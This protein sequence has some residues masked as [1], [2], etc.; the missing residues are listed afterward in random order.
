MSS[1]SPRGDTLRAEAP[2]KINRE[3]RVGGRRS[4][5]YHE[6]RSRFVSIELSDVLEVE[7]APTLELSV[8]GLDIPGSGENLVLRAARLLARELGMEPRARIHL[9]KRI[10]IGAGLGG[11]S[12]DAARALVLLRRLWAPEFSDDALGRLA[13]E[14]GSD[15]PYFLVGGEADVTGRGENVV[16][17]PDEPPVDLLLLFPP[18]PISTKD[19]F[20]EHARRTGGDA[21]L[22]ANL[23]IETSG[24]FFGP[25]DL[26][27]AV[28]G[29]EV[30]M[31]VYLDFAAEIASER[32]MT[33]SGSTVVLRGVAEPIE[34]LL[35]QRHPEASF[36]RTRTL[37]RREYGARTSPP[38]GSTWTSPR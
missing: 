29:I 19:A 28:L 24:K 36:A 16:P 7:P 13:L 11:G 25:N 21:S 35:K 5:G 33:G 26:A 3:L 12:S 1:A 9:K 17:R 31:R 18:F 10:P 2:A 22:P 38:G 15:V 27:S 34:S 32:E 6:L 8:T 20:A 37:P 14:L 4:D 30:A 23:E